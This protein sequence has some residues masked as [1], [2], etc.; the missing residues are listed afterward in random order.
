ME[1]EIQKAFTKRNLP[2]EVKISVKAG[3]EKTHLTLYPGE[4]IRTPTILLLQWQ[5]KNRFSGHNQWRKLLLEY[6][7]PK[8]DGKP[9]ALPVSHTSAYY[10]LF[11]AIARLSSPRTF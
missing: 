7:S 4:S 3:Q 2:R 1:E 9:V 8:I 11:D 5:G 10:R 6:Y